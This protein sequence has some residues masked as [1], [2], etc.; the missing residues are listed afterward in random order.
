MMNLNVQKNTAGIDLLSKISF[1]LNNALLLLLV[2]IEMYSSLILLSV[3]K[4]VQ[5]EE[6]GIKIGFIYG[7]LSHSILYLFLSYIKSSRT[8]LNIENACYLVCASVICPILLIFH[9][10]S[11]DSQ[12]LTFFGFFTSLSVV[13]LTL[14]LTLRKLF[15]GNESRRRVFVPAFAAFSWGAMFYM[16]L[17]PSINTLNLL[18][19]FTNDAFYFHSIIILAVILIV[20]LLLTQISFVVSD[21]QRSKS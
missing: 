9:Q 3:V 13:Q 5:I 8:R 12:L 2:Y 11:T 14:S 7:I 1:G 19:F 20:T 4:A 16:F 21:H 6:I 10:I 18:G 17:E 15:N